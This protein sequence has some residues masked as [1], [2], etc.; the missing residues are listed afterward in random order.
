MVFVI[1]DGIENSVFQSQVLQ[2]LMK[3]L[4]E[5]ATLIITLVS[6]EK[7]RYT[8][9]ELVTII[10]PH[11]RLRVVILKRLPFIIPGSLWW[12]A[13]RL[14][15]WILKQVQDDKIKPLNIVKD[16]AYPNQII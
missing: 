7:H 6:F 11:D 4:Y 1:Y 3:R 13:W 8:Q 15:A 14:K 9:Q 2:L 16:N 5:D 10:L 12:A